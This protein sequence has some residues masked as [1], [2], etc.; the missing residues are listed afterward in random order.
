[1]KNFDDDKNEGNGSSQENDS[2]SS[3]SAPS[4][5]IGTSETHLNYTGKEEHYTDRRNK[6]EN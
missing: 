6:P 3:S 4:T 5:D 1:M 2:G